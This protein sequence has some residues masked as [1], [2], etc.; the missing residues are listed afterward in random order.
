MAEYGMLFIKSQ[1]NN[2]SNKKPS[3]ILNSQVEEVNMKNELIKIRDTFHKES[4]EF[5]VI[6]HFANI[7]IDRVLHGK[8]L[9]NII[10]NQR[11]NLFLILKSR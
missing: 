10:S 7:S 4:N 3:E 5:K 9:E 1:L 8:K 2:D 6:E 11:K